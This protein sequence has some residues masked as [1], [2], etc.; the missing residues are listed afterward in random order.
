MCFGR[1]GHFDPLCREER[2]EAEEPI[3]AHHH[4]AHQGR[5]RTDRLDLYGNGWA[6]RQRQNFHCDLP[7]GHA[8]RNSRGLQNTRYLVQ[9]EQGQAGRAL[10][11]NGCHRAVGR[12]TPGLCRRHGEAIAWF[13][14]ALVCAGEFRCSLGGDSPFCLGCRRQARHS[15][16]PS[17]EE[18]GL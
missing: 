2:P 7:P 13:G 17:G 1:Q 14:G 16:S 8:E 11:R 15:R 10:R 5:R 6:A 18:R 4:P 12:P 9:E 3:P